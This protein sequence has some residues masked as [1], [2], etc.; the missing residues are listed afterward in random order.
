MLL[1]RPIPNIF[2]TLKKKDIKDID[3]FCLRLFF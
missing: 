2:T 3:V 1:H